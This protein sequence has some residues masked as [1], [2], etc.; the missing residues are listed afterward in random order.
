[1]KKRNLISSQEFEQRKAAYI[2]QE[3]SY[4]QAMLRVIFDQPHILIEKAA[5]YQAPDGKKRVRLTLQNTTGGVADYAKLVQ[6]DTSVFDPSLQPDKINNV[7]ISLYESTPNGS[8]G[9]IISQPYEGKIETIR[10]GQTAEMDFLLLKDVDEVVVS[11]TYAGQTDRKNIYLQKDAGAN[12][13]IATSP[14]FSQETD[15]GENATYT[16]SLE[17]FSSENDVFQ[18]T[19]INLPQQIGQ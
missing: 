14:N 10:F 2:N 8:V 16:L 18:L 1:M 19:V 5:K 7:F 6:T 15:L 13:V 4:Q 12:L 3:I 17:R 9:P 11:M